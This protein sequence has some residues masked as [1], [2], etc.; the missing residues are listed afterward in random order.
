VDQNGLPVAGAML[1]T[2]VGYGRWLDVLSDQEGKFDFDFLNLGV[3]RI[4][5]SRGPVR[6]S[7]VVS[8][9]IGDESP[10]PIVIQVKR[11]R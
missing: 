11:R 1:S 2:P 3:A 8:V 6:G 7:K 4:R 5:V 9:E 10:A